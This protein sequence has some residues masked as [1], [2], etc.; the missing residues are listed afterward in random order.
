MLFGGV[1]GVVLMILLWLMI[2]DKPE[3]ALEEQPVTSPQNPQPD[4]AHLGFFSGLY[5]V[6]KNQQA[7]VAAIYAGLMF[8]PTLCFGGCS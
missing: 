4:V 8:V 5:C 1:F 6:L 2:R 3:T 7:W